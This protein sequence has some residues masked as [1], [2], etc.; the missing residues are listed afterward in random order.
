MLLLKAD[1]ISKSY[2]NEFVF[3]DVSVSVEQGQSIAISGPSGSGKTTLLSILGLLLRPSEGDIYWCDENVMSMSPSQIDSLRNQKFGFIFQSANL[4]D[5]LN[6][7]DNVLVPA[8]LG[9]HKALEEKAVQ[10]LSDLGLAHRLDYY[11]EQLSIGQRRR[12][13]LARALLLDPLI[14]LA[15]EPTNDLDPNLSKW[16]GDYLFSLTSKGCALLIATHDTN[17]AARAD[18]RME[19]GSFSQQ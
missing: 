3:R 5:S 18:K 13:A 19:V 12:V 16:V 17:L 15:D 2:E 9:R 11:P 6:V 14:I 10:S 8:Y 4:I 1:K 7:L